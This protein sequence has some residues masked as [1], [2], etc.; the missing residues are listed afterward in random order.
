M[1]IFVHLAKTDRQGFKTARRELMTE[2]QQWPR[3]MR[4]F[5]EAFEPVPGAP[6]KAWRSRKFLAQLYQDKGFLRLSVNRAEVTNDGHWKDGIT[7]DDLQE[8]KRQCGFG[9]CWAVEIFPAEDEVVN[10]AAI[11][12]LFL[13]KSAPSCAWKKGQQSNGTEEANQ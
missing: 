2:N 12:H 6:I 10:V 13:M 4:V 3:E 5:H 7:W 1:S 11:R 9:D 8:V